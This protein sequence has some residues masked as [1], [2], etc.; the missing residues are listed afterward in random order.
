MSEPHVGDVTFFRLFSGTVAN[1]DE[2]YNATR[3][4]RRE[5]EPP[6]RSRRARSASRSRRSTP[7]TSAASRSCATRT[8]TTRSPRAQHPVRLPQI[9]FPEGRSCRWRCTRRTA[10]TRRSCSW[11]C[12]GC[13]TKIPTFE[14]HYNAETHETIVSALGERHLEVGDGEAQAKVRR[15]GRA[16]EAED[17]VSRDDQGARPK[18]RAGTRSSRAAA[19]SSATAGCD[20]RRMPRGAGYEFVDEI[21]GGAIPRQV[22]SGGRQ[23]HPGSGGARHHRRLS[24]GRLPG[25]ECSTARITPWTRTKCRSRWRAFRR[26]RRWRRSAS[27]CCSSRSTR[28]RSSTPD[29][30]MG[31]VLGD[32]SS[33]RGHILGTEPADGR[34][35]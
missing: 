2:V 15:D 5:A 31:D 29:D 24:A 30:Y 19:G 14:T 11:A 28:S 26:S 32:L 6:R 25:R 18:G 35:A 21:V 4:R 16:D 8:R 9:E 23:G 27:P 13:T 10:P 17:R 1:G 22:H 3:E 20:S 12:T 33:R 34:D 7:A